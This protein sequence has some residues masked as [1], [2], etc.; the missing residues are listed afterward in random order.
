MAKR[1]N[2]GS[3]TKKEDKELLIQL[4]NYLDL[5]NKNRTSN[6]ISRLNFFSNAIKLELE[7]KVLTNDYI[8]LDNPFYFDM[9]ELKEKG[10]VKA[11]SKS[12]IYNAENYYRVFKV[13]NNLDVFNPEFRTYCSDVPSVHKGIYIHFQVKFKDVERIIFNDVKD[14]LTVITDII[15]TYFIFEYDSSANTLEIGLVPNDK[16]YLY[17][18]IDSTVLEELEEYKDNFYYNIVLDEETN[19]LNYIEWSNSIG[20]VFQSVK[21]AK[22]VLLYRQSEEFKQLINK[23]NE[24]EE[25]EKKLGLSYSKEDYSFNTDMSGAEYKEFYN[26]TYKPVAKNSHVTTAKLNILEEVDILNLSNEDRTIIFDVF[27]KLE[28]S[29]LTVEEKLKALEELRINYLDN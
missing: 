13:P 7:G 20:K 25:K 5:I 10:V 23:L 18:P 8:T 11:K 6:K 1:M 16:L 19:E 28:N 22:D 21:G 9:E 15:E 14:N 4:D 17:V 29:D 27:D 2:L 12:S 26:T 24:L 3:F